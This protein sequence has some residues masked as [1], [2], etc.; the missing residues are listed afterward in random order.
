MSAPHD[1]VRDWQD[2]VIAETLM[3]LYGWARVERGEPD[4]RWM[5]HPTSLT[6]IYGWFTID[7]ETVARAYLETIGRQSPRHNAGGN[8]R[9]MKAIASGRRRRP[10]NA[11]M[12]SVGWGEM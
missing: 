10:D 7:D 12:K 4:N 6:D 1:D 5:A 3:E 11:W 2:D 9:K 8:A